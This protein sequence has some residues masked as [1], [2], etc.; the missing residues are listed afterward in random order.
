MFAL[1]GESVFII[2]FWFWEEGN[3]QVLGF[4]LF[5]LAEIFG[6]FFFFLIMLDF[7]KVFVFNIVLT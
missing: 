2:G 7:R 6:C 5:F 3:L 4:W 1:K